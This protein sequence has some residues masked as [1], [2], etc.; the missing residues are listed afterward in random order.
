MDAIE[1]YRVQMRPLRQQPTGVRMNSQGRSF[2][3]GYAG[4]SKTVRL[5]LDRYRYSMT[6]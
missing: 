5:V 3:V 4:L 1:L 2:I 6:L